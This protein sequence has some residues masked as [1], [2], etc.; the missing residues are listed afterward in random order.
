[1]GMNGELNDGQHHKVQRLRENGARLL[2]LVNDILD[3]SRIQ[4][5]RVELVQ[6]PFAI[7]VLYDRIASQIG[8]LAAEKNLE[9]T[10]SMDSDVPDVIGGDEKRIEQ[11]IVNLLSNAIKFTESG[12]VSLRSSANLAE[13]TWSIKVSDTGVGIP[14][15]AHEIIFEE[16]RQLDGSASRAYKGSGLGLAISRNLVRIM[17]GTIQVESDL[18]LGSTFTVTLPLIE[19][20]DSQDNVAILETALRPIGG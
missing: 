6:K 15:H 14:P 12:S 7:R 4:A 10:V 17:G 20:T 3:I 1:M 8:V 13:N 5:K 16:F 18:G 11:I 19:E 2:T 9:F